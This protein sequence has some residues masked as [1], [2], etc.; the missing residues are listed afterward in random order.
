MGPF[1]HWSTRRLAPARSAD[2][3]QMETSLEVMFLVT[4]G[5]LS[6]IYAFY[7]EVR[8]GAE[9]DRFL[10][11]LKSE[12]KSEWDALTRSDRFLTIRAVE[13]LR[14]GPLAADAEFQ[15]RYQR[16]RPG[17]RF[18]TAMWV[19]VAAIALVILGTLFLDW[20]W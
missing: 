6:A 2:T 13:I 1:W 10:G 7:L 15:A 11:W 3:P 8:R 5:A 20:N 9:D 19:A 17:K 12:R 14:R 18:E 16:T 4:V